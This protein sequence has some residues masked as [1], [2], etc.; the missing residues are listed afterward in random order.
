MFIEE[1][2]SNIVHVDF[3]RGRNQKQET[4][5]P[6]RRVLSEDMLLPAE[7]PIQKELAQEHAAEPIKSIEDIERLSRHLIQQK[8]YRDNMLFIV[9]I[10]LGLRVSDLVTLRFSDIINENFSFK[11]TFPLLEKK[12]KNTRKVKKNRYLTI[13]DAVMDAVELYLRNCP[14][15]LD[16]YMFKSESNRGSNQNQ[17]LTTFSVERILKKAASEVGID[18]HVSTHTLRKTFGY[19]QMVMGGNDPRRLLLLQKIFG[20]SSVAQT[21]DYIGITGEEIEEAYLGLNLGS[22]SCY[23]KQYASFSSIREIG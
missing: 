3:T 2:A 23:A 16:D 22:S 21:L 11:T 20:H 9:G 1:R 15:K 19:H 4:I 18:C 10:N 17:H 12:T 7:A 5:V 6:T 14:S 13:N 8:R